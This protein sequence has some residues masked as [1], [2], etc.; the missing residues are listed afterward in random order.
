MVSDVIQAESVMKDE[1]IF[2]NIK[3]DILVQL[4]DYCYTQMIGPFV[5]KT[6]VSIQKFHAKK[7]LIGNFKRITGAPI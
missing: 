1:I 4:I 5:N 7:P 6:H 2:S 3:R